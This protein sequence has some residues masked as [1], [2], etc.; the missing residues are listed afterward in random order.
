[1]FSFPIINDYIYQLEV[2]KLNNNNEYDKFLCINRLLK[3]KNIE[4]NLD[5]IDLT[6]SWLL[7][8]IGYY[9]E[10]K[11]KDYQKAIE[12]YLESSY[13]DNS[14]AMNN[15]GYHYQY[16]VKDYPKA[17][18]WY[19]KSINLGN[20]E[21]MNNLGLY[22]KIKNRNIY[23]CISLYIKS[24]ELGNMDGMYFLDQLRIC[25]YLDESVYEHKYKDLYDYV[26]NLAIKQDNNKI[27]NSLL[28]KLPEKYNSI[29]IF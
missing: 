29:N 25:H 4:L 10:Q 24:A 20:S 7:Y 28:D 22:Y 19:T 5:Q 11:E 14:Y 17:I 21:A 8:C 12:W 1:M 16:V 3:N 15:L 26:Y 18:E 13:L 23:E 27:K 9:Y 2:L 6:N